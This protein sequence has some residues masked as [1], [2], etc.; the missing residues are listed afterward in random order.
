MY[1]DFDWI[2]Y[3]NG[4][5][6]AVPGT[7]HHYY[8]PAGLKEVILFTGEGSWY[9]NKRFPRVHPGAA[10][11]WPLAEPLT[12]AE[13][14]KEPSYFIGRD[15]NVE[16]EAFIIGGHPCK[17]Q[18]LRDHDLPY[19]LTSDGYIVRKAWLDVPEEVLLA[20]LP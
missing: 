12:N 7:K 4:N 2:R 17:P 10:R 20:K 1:P 11:D 18:R 16:A 6:I 15:M 5:L 9:S 8:L 13:L 19:M 14:P 3:P